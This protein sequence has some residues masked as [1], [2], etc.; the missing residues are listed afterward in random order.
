VSADAVPADLSQGARWKVEHRTGTAE[1]L[2][3]GPGA[4]AA[5]TSTLIEQPTIRFLHPTS[6]VLVLGSSQSSAIVGDVPGW[7]IRRSG[8][9]AVWLDPAEQVW[10]DVLLPSD[11]LLFDRDVTRSFDWLGQAFKTALLNLGVAEE[12][13]VHAGALVQN[14][15]SSTLCFA[16]QGP[17]EVFAR[18]RKLVGISQRRGRAGAVFQCGLL[19]R[20]TFNDDWFAPLAFSEPVN[21][22][23]RSAGIGLG[24]LLASLPIVA[25]IETNV[26]HAISGLDE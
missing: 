18:G 19:L 7:A 6:S 20:W 5:Q 25:D 10:V 4:S 12:L 2:F 15:W 1:E 13:T 8:G 17:G 21:E 22:S 14:P 16:G 26:E 24:E 11:H 3:S 23:I 9:G